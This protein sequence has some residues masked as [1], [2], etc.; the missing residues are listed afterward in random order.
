MKLY[1]FSSGVHSYHCFLYHYYCTFIVCNS[2]NPVRYT[3]ELHGGPQ[4]YRWTLII[5]ART[6]CTCPCGAYILG[7]GMEKWWECSPPTQEPQVQFQPDLICGLS[8]LSVLPFLQGFF[9][10]SSGFPP[11]WKTN[12][13]GFESESFAR[14]ASFW[15]TIIVSWFH[16]YFSWTFLSKGERCNE[17]IPMWST[18]PWDKARPQ[19][20]ELRALL[21]SISV[22]VL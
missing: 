13:S 4:E 20:R 9:S 7:A 2:T 10:G 14:G 12:I 3:K 11:S 5:I 16:S 17:V 19:H 18:N 1:C 6:T 22:W 21:F 8:K 15:V